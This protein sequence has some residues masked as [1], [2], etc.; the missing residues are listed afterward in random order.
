MRMVP[1]WPLGVLLLAPVQNEFAATRTLAIPLARLRA[2]AM[3]R[4]G[5]GLTRS[6]GDDSFRQSLSQDR[7]FEYTLPSFF[8]WVDEGFF[9]DCT[10]ARGAPCW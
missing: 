1:L 3:K 8:M 6:G 2:R 4:F 5:S 9:Q 7:A 10:R